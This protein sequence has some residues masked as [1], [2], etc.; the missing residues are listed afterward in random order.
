MSTRRHSLCP[1]NDP[2]Q[3]RKRR[4]YRQVQR[5]RFTRPDPGFSLYEGRTRG[6]RMRYTFDDDGDDLDEMSTRRSTRNSDR[7]TPADGPTVTASGR[8]VRPRGGGSYGETLLSG[9]VTDGNTPAT[10]EYEDSEMS[11]AVR[12]GGRGGTRAS[13]RLGQLDGNRKRKTVDGYNEVDG[14]SEEE[15][16]ASSAGWNSADNA[17][18]EEEEDDDVGFESEDEQDDFGTTPN[19]DGAGQ[20]SL[21]VKLKVPSLNP[22]RNGTGTI[23]VATAVEPPRTSAA[24]ESGD[25]SMADVTDGNATAITHPSLSDHDGE[26]KQP[27]NGAHA[28]DADRGISASSA[29]ASSHPPQAEDSKAESSFDATN[30]A[31]TNGMSQTEGQPAASQR[32]IHVVNGVSDGVSATANSALST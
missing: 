8:T 15:D 32:D 1:A 24:L 9:Q 12:A 28:V 17:E 2:L 26:S 22:L 29:Q 6:K 19:G 18:V 7:S 3:K 20:D 11:D 27:L 10:N 25:I 31:M 14:M 4:E 23:K 21:V 16:A 13:T 30:G 5:A